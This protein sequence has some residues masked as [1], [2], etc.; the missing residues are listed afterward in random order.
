M[1]WTGH[2]LW[3]LLDE[4]FR[5]IWLEAGAL[6]SYIMVTILLVAGSAVATGLMPAISLYSGLVLYQIIYLIAYGWV[7]SKRDP[8]MLEVEEPEDA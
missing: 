4:F 8:T 6:A 1:V 5:A 7:V 3:F 2:R